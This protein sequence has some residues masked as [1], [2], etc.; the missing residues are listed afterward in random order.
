VGTAAVRNI[1]S[2]WVW[3]KRIIALATA[4][5][6]ALSSLLAS[7][8][9]ARAAADGTFDPLG[10]ICHHSSAGQSVPLDR[11][12]NGNVCID[13]CCV[14]CL[15]PL[16][17]LPPPPAIVLPSQATISHRLVPIAFIALGGT[18]TA[19]SNRSRAPPYVA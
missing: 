3:R 10:A 12:S 11:H 8:G 7:F 4:Y 5:V 15:M 6:V 19:K 18:R 16:A 1:C 13:C 14:G 2:R 17:V 9:A